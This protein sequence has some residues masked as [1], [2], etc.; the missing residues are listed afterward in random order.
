MEKIL[1]G[2]IGSGTI[3]HNFL[4]CVKQTEGIELYAVYSRAAEKAGALAREYAAKKTYTD[5]EAF[6][7]DEAFNFVY[8]A[9]PNS[10]HYQQAKAALEHGKNVIVEKPFCVHAWQVQALRDLAKEKGLFLIDATPTA[11]LPNLKLLR[12]NLKKIGPV[13]LSLSNYTQ[14]SSRYTKL[15][16]GELTNI[17]DPAFAGGCLSDINYYNIYLNV[18]LFGRPDEVRYY[19][20]LYPGAADTSG[21]AVLRYPGFVSQCTGSKDSHGISQVDIEGEKGFVQVAGG[22]NGL[23]SVRVVCGDEDVTLN[24][25]SEP[26]RWLYEV[27]NMTRLILDD[28]R[29]ELDKNLDITLTVIET[30]ERARDDAG[31][32]FA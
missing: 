26:N 28:G 22:S 16:Q 8:V 6:L 18:A 14:Y 30:L 12:E 13:R 21:I 23:K 2:T 3:V 27:R 32:E 31:I 20:N 4:D 29:E 10:L 11:F 5:M 15:L 17:F 25:Q 19:A 7:S 1:L 24:G 9:T